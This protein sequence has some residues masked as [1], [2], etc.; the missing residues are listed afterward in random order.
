MSSEKEIT[1]VDAKI[2]I[3]KESCRQD[4]RS[5]VELHKEWIDTLKLE[6]ILGDALNSSWI[7][8][9]FPWKDAKGASKGYSTFYWSS[10]CVSRR[11]PP[12]RVIGQSSKVS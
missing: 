12:I 2:I 1:I 5:I 4:I 3:G 7:R 9:R 10:C 6:R 11:R 8:E